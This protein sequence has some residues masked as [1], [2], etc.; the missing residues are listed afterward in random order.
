MA[1]L[2]QD[3]G[4]RRVVSRTTAVC[5]ADPAARRRVKGY[6]FNFERMYWR[7]PKN[8]AEKADRYQWGQ[9][10]SRLKTDHPCTLMEYCIHNENR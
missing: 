4:T 10:D 3:Y 5:V 8:A 7:G 9:R 1:Y 6:Y 2:G